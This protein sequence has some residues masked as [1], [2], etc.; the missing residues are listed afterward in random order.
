[1]KTQARKM[2]NESP[3]QRESRLSRER[4][5]DR[6]K[7]GLCV[8]C[9]EPVFTGK[10]FC[11]PHAKAALESSKRHRKRAKENKIC[12]ICGKTAK[13]RRIYCSKCSQRKNRHRENNPELTLYNTAKNRAKQFGWEFSITVKDIIIPDFCPY[14]K[15][16]LK[17]GKGVSQASSPTI[18]RID[19]SKGY[20]TGNIQVISYKANT[21]K[22]NATQ[23][24]LLLFAQKIEED[25][26]DKWRQEL[27]I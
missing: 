13:T 26:I 1:M 25:F 15:I 8:Q 20:I 24:E 9:G 12:P 10:S 21:M 6:K 5:A 11:E 27:N 23:E 3:K 2:P 22:S 18:D 16:K 4:R 7:Q 17:R 14:L 19:S